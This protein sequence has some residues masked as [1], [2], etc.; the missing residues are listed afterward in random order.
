ME[1]KLIDEKLRKIL[2]DNT[3]MALCDENVKES[4]DLVEDLG[5]DSLT[6][7][8]FISDVE[9]ELDIEFELDELST[10][11]IGKYGSLLELAENKINNKE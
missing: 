4:S 5:L 3:L 7:V 8:S 11:I 1:K 10:D 2:K 9:D 6:L